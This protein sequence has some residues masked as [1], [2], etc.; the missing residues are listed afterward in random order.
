MTMLAEYRYGHGVSLADQGLRRDLSRAMSRWVAAADVEDVVQATLV[1]A[2][3]SPRLPTDPES[4]R[5]FVFAIARQRAADHHRRNKRESRRV[6]DVTEVN[7]PA[8][9][10]PEDADLLR[11]AER[12]LPEADGAKQTLEWMLRESDGETLADIAAEERLNPPVVRKRISRLRR[13]YRE[14]WSRQLATLGVLTLLAVGVAVL[15]HRRPRSTEH[16][17]QPDTPAPMSSEPPSA[18]LAATSLPPPEAPV[19]TAAAPSAI[20]STTKTPQ[21]PVRVGVQRPP[22][23]TDLSSALDE[24]AGK[25]PGAPLQ[26]TSPPTP[27]DRGAAAAALGSVKFQSCALPDGQRGSGH[28]TV[29]FDPSGVVTNATVDSGVF[30]HTAEG[31]CVESLVRALRVPPFEGSPVRVGKS[32][33]IQ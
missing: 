24:A 19:A 8:A 18:T 30:I 31:R 5:K 11:W 13:F 6:L 29:T 2:L 17:M 22:N 23:S 3:A 28:V 21:Q 14:R 26:Q 20:A 9:S 4:I 32:F 16:A 7:D 25:A 10:H 15:A 12:E 27:F 33:T 1:E